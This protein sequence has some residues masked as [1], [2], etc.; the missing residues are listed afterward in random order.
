MAFA[1]T[2]EKLCIYWKIHLSSSFQVSCLLQL[3]G[4]TFLSA[5][6][7]RGNGVCTAHSPVRYTVLRQFWGV[8]VDMFLFYTSKPNNN[9]ANI[10]SGTE[11]KN[12]L[13][14]PSLP[15]AHS[16]PLRC[17]DFL[18]LCCMGTSIHLLDLPSY[19]G[20]F[21]LWLYTK[22]KIKMIKSHPCFPVC[23][24]PTALCCLGI[25]SDTHWFGLGACCQK[26]FSF[27]RQLGGQEP[28]VSKCVWTS[29]LHRGDSCTYL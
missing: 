17:T 9:K 16:W 4:T 20:S 26:S 14:S 3:K 22:P 7:T 11:R 21:L 6:G 24:Q 25:S 15:W 5:F 8:R 28:A 1:R 10:P 13:D 27:S 23:L 2:F 12:W 18:L 29:P 19:P